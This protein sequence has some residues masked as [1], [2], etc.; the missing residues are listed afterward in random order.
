MDLVLVIL[1]LA[2]LYVGWNIGANDTANCI[3]T[4]V[5]SG[6][7]SFKKAVILVSIFAMAGAML[8]GHHVMKTIGKGIITEQLPVMPVCVALFCS[9]FFVT[10][11]TFF[12][13][14]VSTSHA[15]VGG[16]AG[17][18]LA[19]SADMNFSV[20]GKIVQ[21]WV[22]CPLLSLVLSYTLYQLI[23]L[24]IR[25]FKLETTGSYRVLSLLVI[26][27]ACYMAYSMGANNV[28]NAV[29]PITNLGKVA[30]GP[31]ILCLLGSAALAVGVMT[32]GKRVTE[33]VGKSI[34]P[35]DLP[36]A[37]A[38]QIAAAFGIHLFSMLGIPVSTSQAAVGAVIGVG[39]VRG[40]RAV[41]FKQIGLIAVGWVVVPAM[42]ALFSFTILTLLGG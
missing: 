29:G 6:I 18:G 35:L 13:V 1:V 37:L 22:Y 19:A 5:G 8:Q 32:F 17:V 30:I 4:S 26:L 12:K 34:T 7:I 3:G 23:L 31:R 11:A 33:T 16:V 28:G 41:S 10:L 38:A 40:V 39:L 36:G 9:G 2:G 27:S 25:R 20:I 21:C 42:G 15:M 14:P 24:I